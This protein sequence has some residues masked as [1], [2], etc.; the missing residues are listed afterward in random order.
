MA[1]EL[2]RN[3]MVEPDWH[4]LDPICDGIIVDENVMDDRCDDVQQ[5]GFTVENFTAEIERTA[6]ILVMAE[7]YEAIGPLCRLALPLYEK[8][9]D[10]RALVN[11]YA[12]LQQAYSFADQVKITRKRHFGTYYRIYFH[13]A[14]HF[15]EDHKTE[16]IY[17]EPGCTSLAEACER[18][19]ESCRVAL[20]HERIQIFAECEMNESDLDENVAY[21]QMTHVEPVYANDERDLFNI[22]TNVRRFTYETSMVDSAVPSDAA[23][24]SRQALKRTFL[25]SKAP[26]PNTRRRQLVVDRS[27]VTLSPLELACDKLMFKARE[28]RRVLDDASMGGIS[29]VHQLDVKGLQLLL[30]GAIQPTVNIGPLAYAEAFTS[31]NQVRRYGRKGI[32]Q[33]TD[34]FRDLIRVCAEALKVNK[35]AIAADQ[36]EYQNM[37]ENAFAAMV[38]RLHSFFGESVLPHSQNS[39]INDLNQ[40]PNDFAPRTSMH[41]FDSIGGVSS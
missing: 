8:R 32:Q 14:N 31:A 36:T 6:Q 3:G 22:H 28:I 5:A 23:D 33:L 11:M 20:G 25:T 38:E 27:V 15:K 40:S 4:L 24:V 37:L 21:V 12:E 2:A 13:G 35:A 41:L 18:M 17:R 10:Y 19:K 34:A 1:K 39:L 7:R 26:F 29:G 30:Q 16:W 9:K